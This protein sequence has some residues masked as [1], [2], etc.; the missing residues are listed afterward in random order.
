MNSHQITAAIAAE[1]SA[2]FHAEA[3]ASRLA[4]LAT[5]RTATTARTARPAAGLFRRWTAAAA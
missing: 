3:A 1:R 5:K 2:T 4:K